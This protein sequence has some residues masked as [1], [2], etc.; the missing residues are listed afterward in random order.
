MG[1]KHRLVI[2]QEME[3]RKKRYEN[4]NDYFN[5][6]KAFLLFHLKMYEKNAKEKEYILH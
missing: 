2:F 5:C 1:K 4:S 6:E 3:W